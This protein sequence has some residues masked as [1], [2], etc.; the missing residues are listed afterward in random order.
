MANSS[1]NAISKDV[2]LASFP[3]KIPSIEGQITLKELLRC[4]THLIECAQ[5]SVTEYNELNFLFIVVPQNLW[6]IY[7]NTPYPADPVN[8]GAIPPYQAGMPPAQ[9]QL[10]KDAWNAAKKYHEEHQ[11]MNKALTE[12][13]MTI[14]PREH[15]LGYQAILTRNPNRPFKDTFD[16]FFNEFATQDEVEIED[17]KDEMKKPWKISEGFQVLKQRIQDGLTYAAFAG[18]PIGA[19]DVLNMMMVVLAH[20]QLFAREYQD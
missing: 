13:F 20:T 8:P 4:F 7:T 6:N 3:T 12:R 1:S 17:N 18:K 2:M 11:H 14:L 9:I 5:L 10:I 19:D 15:Q 16:Y